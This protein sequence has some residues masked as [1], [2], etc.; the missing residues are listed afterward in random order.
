MI[1]QN[2]FLLNGLNRTQNGLYLIEIKETCDGPEAT[3]ETLV[4]LRFRSFYPVFGGKWTQ[5]GPRF[6]NCLP[7]RHKSGRNPA[8][9]E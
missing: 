8:S 7:S 3:T 6:L 1:C 5:I 9:F 2:V 4:L